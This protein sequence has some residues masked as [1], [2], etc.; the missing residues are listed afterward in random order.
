[1]LT[2]VAAQG[3]IVGWHAPSA[4]VFGAIDIAQ[5]AKK[6]GGRTRPLSR[7]R[8]SRGSALV[9]A[10]EIHHLDPCG[11]EVLRELRLR[12]GAGVDLGDGT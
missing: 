11:H 5:A 2:M 3:A 6:E 12:V 1:M 4:A 10:V 7:Q 9:E 8:R